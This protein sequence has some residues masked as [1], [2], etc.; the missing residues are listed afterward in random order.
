M[1]KEI[2]SILVRFL[3]R[4]PFYGVQFHPEKNVYEW[5]RNRNIPHTKDS[6]AIAQYFETFL[7]NEC[8]MNGNRFS[9]VDVE[10]QVLIYNFPATFTGRLN[11]TFEQCYL[12]EPNIDYPYTEIEAKLV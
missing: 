5:A 8:R 4:Y 1:L 3:C 11:S 2:L 12:F 10:N 6:I 7:V 9:G